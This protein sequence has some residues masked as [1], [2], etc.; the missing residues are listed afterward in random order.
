VREVHEE[1]SARDVGYT[2]V[3]KLMQIMAEKGLVIRDESTR[4]HVYRAAIQESDTK[5]RLVADL[6]ERVFE[7]SAMSL[8]LHALENQPATAEDLEEIRNLLDRRSKERA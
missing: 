2:T 8:V 6:A 7:G 5:R 4:S 3:L 1:L